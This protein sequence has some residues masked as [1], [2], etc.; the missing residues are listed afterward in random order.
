MIND[1]KISPTF[2]LWKFID[3]TSISE[4]IPK[5]SNSV[6]QPAVDEMVVWSDQNRFQLH[7]TKSKELR[8]DFSKQ[9][10]CFQPIQVEG[11]QLEVVKTAKI[12]GL[13][14][15]NDL[16]WNAHID[17]VLKKASK[18]L[19]FLVQLKRARVRTNELC[20]FYTT[21]IR[22]VIEYSC[23]VYHFALPEYLSD[24]LE[25]LQRRA[26][27]IIYPNLSYD[28]AITAAG[29]KMLQERRLQLC[30]KLF[31]EISCNSDHKLYNL[32]PPANTKPYQL[33]TSCPFVQP[34]SR[35]NRY[36]N[37]FINASIRKF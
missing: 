33:R 5:M 17:A 4:V 23:Q 7:P 36:K 3:D 37:S 27:R 18:R 12:L 15:S 30:K 9:P 25:R 2:Y 21:C 34:K 16:K 35:T 20:S 10:R 8:I 6:I 28:Q 19:Y 31:T 32:L 11:R 22:S 1:L 29:V 24:N 14:V 13:V 26:L